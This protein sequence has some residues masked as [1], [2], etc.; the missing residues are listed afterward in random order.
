MKFRLIRAG[1]KSL[2][3]SHTILMKSFYL[4][5]ILCWFQL[6]SY[7]II[8]H[9]FLYVLN[10]FSLFS[11]LKYQQKLRVC[12]LR[13]SRAIIFQHDRDDSNGRVSQLRYL[14]LI[15]KITVDVFFHVSISVVFIN[16]LIYF[17][18]M[19]LSIIKEGQ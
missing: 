19:R 8:F 1:N 7:F 6:W 2:I 11:R 4:I 12:F 5:K 14:F 15:T 18:D 17:V 9:F 3:N 13:A 16:Y 10:D